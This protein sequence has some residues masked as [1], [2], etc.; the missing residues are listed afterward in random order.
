MTSAQLA[1]QV[2]TGGPG[3]QSRMQH[4]DSPG[5]PASCMYTT[6]TVMP[7]CRAE[8]AHT[9]TQRA[10]GEA[11]QAHGR[12]LQRHDHAAPH[13]GGACPLAAATHVGGSGLR[14]RQVCSASGEQRAQAVRQHATARSCRR[15]KPR[16]SRRKA[17]GVQLP[18]G[19]GAA[20]RRELQGTVCSPEPL[21]LR[22]GDVHQCCWAI[23]RWPGV[24]RERAASSC[25]SGAAAAGLSPRGR[26]ITPRTP[27]AGQRAHR[28]APGQLFNHGL[29][30]WRAVRRGTLSGGV[31]APLQALGSRAPAHPPAN[32]PSENSSKAAAWSGGARL[33]LI[34]SLPCLRFWDRGGSRRPQNWASMS[35]AA[36]ARCLPLPQAPCWPLAWPVVRVRRGA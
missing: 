26:S 15:A 7:G 32:K 18:G 17:R 20:G 24:R 13:D 10:A 12:R 19:G 4:P 30:L 11:A 31:P 14:I 8:G 36:A 16:A 3:R 9:H 1:L 27:C 29:P 5:A 6:F 22:H 34:A 35:C 25:P 23:Q 28:E 21:S 33:L 2:D